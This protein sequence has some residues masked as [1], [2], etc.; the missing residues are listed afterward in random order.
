MTLAVGGTL[1]AN[2]TTTTTSMGVDS[3][4]EQM[5]VSFIIQQ[6]THL[7]YSL[8]KICIGKE[9]ALNR[10]QRMTQIQRVCV[11]CLGRGVKIIKFSTC[12]GTSKWL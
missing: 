8:I 4:E 2:T 5:F 6:E 11:K 10:V 9:L 1:N 12:P 7:F 3:I